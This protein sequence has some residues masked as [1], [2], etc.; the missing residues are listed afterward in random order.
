MKFWAIIIAILILLVMITVH[1]FGHYCAGKI[2]KF[3]INEFSIGMGPAIFKKKKKNGEL[4]AVR[5]FPLGGYCAFEG[6]DEEKKDVEGAF[7]TKKPW[8]RIIVL[9]SGAL[10]NFLLALLVIIVMFS[11]YGETA[12]S[13]FEVKDNPAYVYSLQDEDV[14]VELN[15]KRI[16][17]T[18]DLVK[19][20]NGK[21][22]GSVIKAKVQRN[23][24]KQNIKI[25]LRSDVKCKDVTDVAT[26]C[27]AL[28]IATLAEVKTE[29]SALISSGFT[30]G[31]Y[32]LRIKEYE[33]DY[34][35]E[36][37]FS[38]K[39]IY[40]KNGLIEALRE[41]NGKLEIFVASSKRA[42][43]DAVNPES[44]TKRFLL[45]LDISDIFSGKEADEVTEKEILSALN[46]DGVDAYYR[47]STVKYKGNFF[48]T[49]GD[50]FLYSFKIGGVI[51]TTLGQ[52]LTGKL[53]LSSVGGPV[54]TVVTTSKIVG[55][56]LG[57]LLEIMAFIGVNLA[58]FNL[59][60]IPALDGSRVVFTLIE[61]IFKKPVPKKIEGV[62]HAVGLLVLLGFSI[63]VDVLQ[64]I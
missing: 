41:K 12:Y 33:G 31:D 30:S 13:S 7:N 44:D 64:F 8:Q 35:E 5:I 39:R 11:S 34:S 22:E 54:T 57:Y 6:E 56:G 14:L 1:E 61:W 29:N 27:K 63:L 28:G 10:M 49:I 51:F 21:K 36:K 60:P 59:L 48:N 32:L 20:V 46:V 58:V 15:G 42:D 45:S 24:K 17:L 9:I 43:K 37:Y 26:V 16:M 55:M 38:C 3:K 62:I 18:T 53:G 19:S 25:E 23:G 2:F 4:F 40:D 47:V 52:L 50:S